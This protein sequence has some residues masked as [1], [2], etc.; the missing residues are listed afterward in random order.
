MSAGVDPSGNPRYLISAVSV[1]QATGTLAWTG[2]ETLPVLLGGVLTV[3]V[4]AGL[5]LVGR[6]RRTA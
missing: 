4:G 5:V 6:R 2:F 1:A 3:A